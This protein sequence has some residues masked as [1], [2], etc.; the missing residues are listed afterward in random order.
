MNG[1]FPKDD[2]LSL[3][4]A[5][6]KQLDSYSRVPKNKWFREVCFCLLTP[7]SSPF[8]AELSLIQLEN[9]GFFDEL[10][11][12]QGVSEILRAPP[13]YVRFHHQKAKRLIEILNKR[14]LIEKI[15]NINVSPIEERELLMANVS[16]FGLKE[17]SHA[18]RNIGRRGLGILDRH[19]LRALYH[20]N[21]ITVVPEVLTLKTYKE[22]EALMNQFSHYHGVTI[23]QMDLFMWAQSTYLIFK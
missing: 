10:L 3:R 16:G 5:I 18:L 7:Q 23:D 22:I 8:N 20:W 14:D 6:D 17:S 4:S 9:E 1:Q 12:F 15:L 11:N 19:I 2:F 13:S 21:A